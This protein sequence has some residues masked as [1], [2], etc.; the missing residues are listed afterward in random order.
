MLEICPH[1]RDKCHWLKHDKTGISPGTTISIWLTWPNHPS[2]RTVAL[3]RKKLASTK[4][5]PESYCSAAIQ[6]HTVEIQKKWLIPFN[7]L[8]TMSLINFRSVLNVS[9][10]YFCKKQIW[11]KIGIDRVHF[12][13]NVSVIFCWLFPGPKDWFLNDFM[14][15][16][17]HIT[18][19]E[20]CNTSFAF[21]LATY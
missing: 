1:N 6:F 18:S 20:W 21:A 4:T 9:L 8:I 12:F 11:I 14:I 2:C 15:D 13:L 7:Y 16:A 10:F 5:F 3:R 19:L 17:N